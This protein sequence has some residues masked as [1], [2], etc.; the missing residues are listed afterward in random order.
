MKLSATVT[1]LV[2][3]MEGEV[4]A[5]QKRGCARPAA[6]AARRAGQAPDRNLGL[7]QPGA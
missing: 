2:K 7:S 3:L 4:K 5:G 1:D 6:G